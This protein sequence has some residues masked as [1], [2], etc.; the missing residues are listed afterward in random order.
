MGLTPESQ[1]Q[2]T[3]QGWLIAQVL[4]APQGPSTPLPS[5]SS[6]DPRGQAVLFP[7]PREE[8][9]AW[10]PQAHRAAQCRGGV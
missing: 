2:A 9:E 8:A 1:A 10:I 7:F 4:P 3:P 6:H 5:A